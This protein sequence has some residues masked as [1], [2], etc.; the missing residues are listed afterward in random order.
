VGP[1]V[2]THLD[3]RL[4][5]IA[6]PGI[7]VRA[8]KNYTTVEAARE[9]GISRN[10]IYQWMKSKKIKGGRVIRFGISAG[11]T[12]RVWTEGDLAAIQQWMSE[13]PYAGRGKKRG[14]YLRAHVLVPS[15]DV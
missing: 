9:L 10:T 3:A 12:L 7:E 4:S 5:H 6:T 2:S 1:F 14:K 11:V 8:L 13:N 15:S